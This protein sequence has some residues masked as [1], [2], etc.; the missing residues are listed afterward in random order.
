[1][2]SVTE[3]QRIETLDVLRGFAL[4]GILLLNI[5]GF[6][7]HS[8]SYSNPGFDLLPGST[9]DL[10]T[11]ATVELFAEGAMRCLFS[12]LFGAGV[13]LFLGNRE[14][15]G[16][17]HYRRTFLLM[18]FGLLDLYLLLWNGDILFTYALAGFI[19]YGFRETSARKL[20]IMSVSLIFLMSI[21][22]VGVRFGLMSAAAAATEVSQAANPDSISPEIQ[23][24]AKGWDD[25][26]RDYEPTP[27]MISAEYDSR[28]TSYLTAFQWNLG[29]ANTVIL[30][31]IP[32]FLLWDALAMMMIGM[33]LYRMGI[34]QGERS[35]AFYLKLMLGGFGLG[36]AINAFEVYQ[37]INSD[38]EIFS[39]FAQMQGTY[40]FGRL[41]MALGYIGLWG[42]ICQRGTLQFFREALASVGRLALTNYLMQSLIC[43]I[44]FTGAGFALVG[45]LSRSELYPLVLSIQLFQLVF[46]T[47]WLRYFVMGPIEWLW[48]GL[49]YGELPN[50]RRVQPG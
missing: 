41:G 15:R 36:L 18:L 25:F 7:L 33:A 2:V 19:L 46:S 17:L 23:E 50:F 22:H 24:A 27:D 30:M 21:M 14:G 16:K 11:W 4:L 47:V 42:L 48:R 39:V 13:I 9:A 32:V 29:K 38:F 10:V 8:A 3:K 44:L 43:L 5:L 45:E 35:P 1:M 12:I 6:G 40:H 37:A 34:L 26:I 28:R 20:L 49:T 31:V